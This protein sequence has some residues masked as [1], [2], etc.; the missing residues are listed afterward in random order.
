[1]IL[2]LFGVSCVRAGCFPDRAGCI[3]LVVRVFWLVRLGA[4]A[5]VQDGPASRA[6]PVSDGVAGL[7]ACLAQRF[8]AHHGEDHEYVVGQVLGR[9]VVRARL[10][11]DQLGQPGQPGVLDLVAVPVGAWLVLDHGLD[12]RAGTEIDRNVRLARTSAV[13]SRTAYT[14]ARL[15]RAM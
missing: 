13:S 8:A 12:R 10:V 4:L 11:L 2:L 5:L 1:M 3:D 15:I 14:S 9:S 7:A 6:V